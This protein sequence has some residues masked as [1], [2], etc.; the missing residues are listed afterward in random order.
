MMTLILIMKD[1]KVRIFEQVRRI[2]KLDSLRYSELEIIRH[3]SVGRMEP[4]TVDCRDIADVRV[5]GWE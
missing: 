5:T 2:E 4:E 3:I 1:G